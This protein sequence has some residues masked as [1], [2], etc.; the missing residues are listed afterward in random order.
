M[1]ERRKFITGLISLVAAPAIVRVASIM[2]IKAMPVG[3]I[4]GSLNAEEAAAYYAR[5]KTYFK[6]TGVWDKLDALYIYGAPTEEFA[7]TNLVTGKKDCTYAR[8]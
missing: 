6:E 4:G 8:K 5:L 3:F 2:P 1:L 7:L